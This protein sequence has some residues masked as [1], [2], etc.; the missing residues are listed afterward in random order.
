[1]DSITAL[2]AGGNEAVTEP[3][4]PSRRANSAPQVSPLRPDPEFILSTIADELV[5][6]FSAYQSDAAAG[7]AGAG[8]LRRA[9]AVAR[10]AHEGQKRV[11]GEP[12]IDH[13]V[14]VAGLLLDL[15]LDAASISAALLHDVVE[16]T[17]VTKEQ[18][19]QAFGGEVAHL[20]DGVTKLSAL[21]AQTKED[22]QVGTYR[23]MFIAMADDPR[24]VLVKLA[25]RLHNMRTISAMKPDSQKRIARET[26]DI[27]APLAHRLGIWQIK[28]EL[29]DKSFAILQ[30]EKYQ[31]ISRQ[32]AL[33]RDAREKI[34]QRV[35]A[36]LHQ[37]LDKEGIKADIT[38]RPKHIYSIYRK[39]ERKGVSLDQIYDQL[40]VR[41]IV[42]NVGECYQVLG[43]VHAIW[44]PVPGE[45]D[46][47]IAMPK[48]SMYRSLH[49]TVLIPGGQ[50]CEIQIRTHEMHEVSEHGIAA[51]WRY[52]EGFGRSDA[53]F[54][55]KL[56]WL[57]GLIEWRR[58]LTDAHEFVES[59]KSDVLEEQVYVFTPKGKILDLP[60]GSTPVDFAYRIH[61]QVGH[62]C[63]GAKVNNRMVPLDYQLH[64]GEIVQVMTSKNARGPSRDWLNFV[65]TSGARNHIRRYFKRLHRDENVTAGRDLLEKELKRLG[66]SVPFE[67]IAQIAGVKTIEDLFAQIGS[68]DTTART[69]A[70]KILS[71]RAR[72]ED[73]ALADIPQVAPQPDRT[74]DP[75]GISVR[76]VDGVLT[77]LAKCCNPVIGEPIVG[78]VTR[79]K[80]IT[81]HRA[82]CRQ[83]INE[84]DRARLVEVTWGEASPQQ[85]YPVHV[86]IEAWD[87]VGLWRDIS[88]TVADAGIN[89]Q[90]V[91]QVPT[92]KPD[93]AVLMTTLLIQSIAQLSTILDK[94]NR[95]PDVIE[96]RREQ[97]GLTPS[98]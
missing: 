87:R 59:L 50:P 77:R 27:Y 26:L 8:L 75:K 47:Y 98:A 58:D 94:L 39:M 57:R 18:V 20:V 84:R 55:A 23:K 4:R 69:V 52:K 28:W 2:A 97:S 86:R 91:Q 1:M 62:S 92:R 71:Q 89:I 78:F 74:T 12:Y 80:G 76:G 37:A 46:D 61:T 96:A 33:R 42:N 34:I 11:S 56:A 67:E 6:R 85:G 65:Q 25:D 81:V 90:E 45:F 54:E 36:R 82:D 93:R 24:V 35:I 14:A 22:A 53:S 30:P 70:Q 21:E 68:G 95:L 9:Y 44:P 38:G 51:H 17:S 16:D 64:S 83:V 49:S 60:V 43:I 5:V 3:S 19:E 41:V 7:E 32:L 29:E 48:E 40:A 66:M 88:G 72:S 73:A 63:A 15:R 79:G 13:P 31:E 10:E